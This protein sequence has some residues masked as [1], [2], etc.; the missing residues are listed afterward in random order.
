MSRRRSWQAAKSSSESHADI[1]LEV[2][3][4]VTILHKLQEIREDCPPGELKHLSNRRKRNQSR[5]RY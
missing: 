2:T 1:E 3:E 5:C 4:F